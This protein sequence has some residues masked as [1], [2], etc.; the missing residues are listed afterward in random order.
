MASSARPHCWPTNMSMGV[1]LCSV[2][3][4]LTNITCHESPYR[5]WVNSAASLAALSNHQCR[6]MVCVGISAPFCSSKLRIGLPPAIRTA[7]RVLVLRRRPFI[8]DHPRRPK[9]I[10]EHCEP[11]SEECFLHRHEDLTSIEK[12][13]KNTLGVAAGVHGEGE[14]NAA[15][16]LKTFRTNVTSHQF[17]FANAHAGIQDGVFL[18]GRYVLCIGLFALG[19]HHGDLAAQMFLIETE[20]LRAISTVVEIGM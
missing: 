7:T 2:L 14:I 8:N 4:S 17:G 20:R 10:A 6:V 15:H 9:F 11:V 3:R 16:R 12:Q 5:S 18:V 13:S 19:H 1:M